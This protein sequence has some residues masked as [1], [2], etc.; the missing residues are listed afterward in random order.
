M[1]QTRTLTLICLLCVTL[2]T[3]GCNSFRVTESKVNEEVAQ[4]LAKP[5]QN[6]I[7]L[8]LDG[9]TLNLDFLVSSANIDFTERD[10]GLVLVDLI[11]KIT[12]T[13]TAF[14]Q[15]FSLTTRVNPSFESGVRIEEDRL[16][17]VAPKI[18]KIEVEGSS[19]SDKLL[20]STLGPLHEDFERALVQ[21]FDGHP[22]YVLNHSPFEKAAAVM[23]KDIIIKE[24]SLELSIF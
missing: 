2:L 14:G 4:Q 24:D 10:G 1:S 15:N 5:Q 6:Q 22:V 12:G 19:F 23:V 3:A 21:Y 11:G 16:Y 17:L 7:E 13:V 20:R 18:T 9:N 8:T